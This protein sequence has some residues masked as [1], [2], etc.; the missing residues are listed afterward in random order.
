[1]FCAWV[2]GLGRIHERGFCKMDV[3]LRAIAPPARNV[4]QQMCPCHQL[5]WQHHIS[6][7]VKPMRGKRRNGNCASLQRWHPELGY[8]A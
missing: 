2:K 7:E 4:Q 8:L 1:M 6:K 5:S 3:K